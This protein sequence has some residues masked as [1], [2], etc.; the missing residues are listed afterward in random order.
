MGRS[1][2]H[3]V[4]VV[5]PLVS[6]SHA[7]IRHLGAT[8]EVSDLGSTHGTFLAGERIRGVVTG[9]LPASMQ[10]GPAGPVLHLVHETSAPSP[11][12]GRGA[13]HEVLIGRD[14]ACEVRLGDLLVSRRHARI[15]WDG[16]SPVVED[17]GSVNGTYVDGHRITRAEIDADSLLMVGG[18]R[19]QVDASGVRLIEGT[20]VR[21]ATVGLG[22]TLPSG[23]TL[24]DDVSFSL[25]PG[26]L[27]AVIGGSGTG[28]TTWRI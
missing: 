15:S 16:P 6:R 23:R 3:R 13:F 20:E 1:D 5:H 9:T 18:S 12:L 2:E 24:L 17:L 21:F 8:C 26:A 14:H 11:A 4:Q 27:M 10:L 19:L 28:N 7:R 22:V 25:A